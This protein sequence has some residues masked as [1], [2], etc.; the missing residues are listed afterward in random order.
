[1]VYIKQLVGREEREGNKVVVTNSRKIELNYMRHHVANWVESVSVHS[2]G[3]RKTTNGDH[4]SLNHRKH[5]C[6]QIEV[7]ML[8][9]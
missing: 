4:V 8:G 1:M 2:S 9:S 7:M 6:E 5:E 3:A